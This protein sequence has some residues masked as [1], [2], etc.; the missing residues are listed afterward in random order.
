MNAPAKI[1]GLATA[2]RAMA[3]MQLDVA[4]AVV[5]G[6]HDVQPLDEISTDYTVTPE[7][8]REQISAAQKWGLRFVTLPELTKAWREGQPLDGLASVVFDDAL[9]GVHRYAAS[10]LADLNVP[11]TLFPLTVGLGHRPSWWSGSART[12]T[13]RENEELLALGW[14]LGSHTRTHASLPMLDPNRQREEIIGSKQELEDSTGK[15]VNM[16]AYPFGHHDERVRATCRDAG[17]QVG[18]TFLNGRIV[19]DLDAFRLPRLTMTM[20]SRGL[21]WAYRL[22]RSASSWPDTQ[23]D[24]VEERPRE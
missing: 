1:A 16:I 18:F 4:G 3:G 22:M 15:A 11:G 13:A 19:S 9:V 8:L 21:R 10:I 14:S 5:L 12:M 23:V 20:S 24:R 6:Y 17:Y 7:R 2:L